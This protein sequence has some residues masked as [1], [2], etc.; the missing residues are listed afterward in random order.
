MKLFYSKQKS[1]ESEESKESLIQEIHDSFYNA[2]NEL[3]NSMDALIP[4]NANDALLEKAKQLKKLGFYN[5]A[6]VHLSYKEQKRINEIID[7]NKEKEAIT[8]AIE[9]FSFKY[10]HKKFIDEASVKQICEKYGLIYGTIDHYRGT[11]PD[12][13]LEE[14][15]NFKLDKVDEVY[16]YEEYSGSF[17]LKFEKVTYLSE[18]WLEVTKNRGRIGNHTGN[19]IRYGKCKL[20]IV[21]PPNDFDKELVENFK[22]IDTPPIPDPIVLQPVLYSLQ[23]K[24]YKHYDRSYKFYLILSAWGLEASDELVINPKNN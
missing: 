24:H 6:E 3:L 4:V 22:I 12:K 14:I 7:K 2:Q 8:K 11:I 15:A 16:Y 13:N 17:T 1:K 20:E 5:A 9:Y 18:Q 21:A 10:P 19:S 23:D